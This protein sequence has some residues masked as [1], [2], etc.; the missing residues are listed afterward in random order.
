MEQISH[1][2]FSGIYKKEFN[3]HFHHPSLDACK[4]CNEMGSENRSSKHF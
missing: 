4:F 2:A 3:L 1:T